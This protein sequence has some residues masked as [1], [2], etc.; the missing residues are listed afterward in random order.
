MKKQDT[1]ENQVNHSYIGIGSNLG[2]RK[3][4]IEYTKHLL[5]KKNIKIIKSSSFYLT[6]SWPNEKFPEFIN[7][8]LF[9]KTNLKLKTFFKVLKNIEIQLGRKKA[10]RNHPRICDIDILD[11]N[12]NVVERKFYNFDLEIPHPRMHRRNFVLFPLFEINKKWLHPKF[13]TNIMN[14]ISK[15]PQNAIRGIKL[16]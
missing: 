16:F 12:G 5:I 8:V 13:K 4:N 15:L 2:N 11:Y 3:K 7:I 9:V 6:K 10:Q 1:S 14:L